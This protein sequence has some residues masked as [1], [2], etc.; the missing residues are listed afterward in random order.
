MCEKRGLAL[1]LAVLALAMA[2]GAEDGYD[3]WLRYAPISDPVRLEYCRSRCTE[4]VAAAAS[5]E[6]DAATW[7]MERGLSHMLDREIPVV[8]AASRPGG[9]M[10]LVKK[11]DLSALSVEDQQRARLTEGFIILTTIVDGR[12]TTVV[13]SETRRGLIYGVFHYLRLVSTG[14]ALDNLSVLEQPAVPLRMIDHWDNFDGTVERGYAGRSIFRWDQLPIGDSRYTDYARLLAS[15]G[16]NGLAVNNVNAAT[17]ILRADMLQKLAVLAESFREYQIPLYVSINFA[18]PMRLGGLPTADPQEPAV[19]RWW[20]E[21]ADE[22]YR[23]IPDF[24]GFL[25]KANSEGQPGPQDYGRSHAQGANMLARALA[26]HGG[27]VIW[28]AFV[29]R[30]GRADRARESYD[31]FEPLDGQFDANVLVQIKNGPIDFQIREPVHPLFGQMPRTGTMLE[32]QITQEYTGRSTHLV[33]LVPTWK[34]VLDFDTYGAGRNSTVARLVAG[35]V[36]PYRYCGMAGVSNVGDDRNWAGHHFAAANL[37]GYGRLAWNP[38]LAAET[39]AEEWTRQTWGDDPVVV[40]TIVGMLLPS[41]AIYEKYTIPLAAGPMCGRNHYDPDPAAPNRVY[42]H[43]ADSLGVGF[44]RTRRTG[45][46]YTQQYRAFN[47]QRLD[48]RETCPEELLLFFHHVAYNYRLKSGKTLIQYIYDA[49][50]AGVQEAGGL[51]E[52]WV[53]LQ[54]KIDAQRFREVRDK[55]EAQIKHAEKW[56]DAINGYFYQLSGIPDDQG[57]IAP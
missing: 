26:P 55:L 41:A 2:A 12:P 4:I 18:S 28:R 32:L 1:A 29:Y 9:V 36:F 38:E 48:S 6:W 24:G 35:K 33:Y 17:E 11:S 30:S 34:E 8:A 19:Q 51:R 54:G 50:Y 13:S 10:L 25:V 31:E 40:K 49:H 44:D 16:I 15:V 42:Y 22:I 39:I 46:G 52:A 56:R 47:T 7:E 20:K 14:A 57:R 23:L 21:K 45:S 53:S 43:H 5:R 3:A 27:I 37:Y